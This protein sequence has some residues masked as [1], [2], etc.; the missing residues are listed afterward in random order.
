MA[1]M[2]RGAG[3][4]VPSRRAALPVMVHRDG[5]ATLAAWTQEHGEWIGAALLEHGAVLFRG[6]GVDSEQAFR[7]ASAALCG[8]LLDYVYRSTPRTTVGDRVYTA[9]EYPAEV[10]IPMHNE[11]AFQ[12]TWPMKLAFCCVRP[13]A[14]GGETPLARTAAVTRRIDPAILRAFAARGVMYVR[15]YGHGVDLPW[16]TT[17]QT[18]SPAEVEAYC[19]REGIA[20]EWLPEGRLRTRQVCQGVARHPTTGE[21]LW[22]NQAHLFHVSSL[23]PEQRD[24]LLELFDEADLPR[25]ACFGDGQPIDEATLEHVR[26]AYE[27]ETSMFPWQAGDVLLVDNMLVAHGR[28]AFTG[29]RRV[30]VAMGDPI[31]A[32][33]RPR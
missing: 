25:H 15:N 19:A 32:A 2:S 5:A 6:F 13:A 29:A 33:V 10:S 8:P 9:T 7:H 3:A 1:V 21:E 31:P 26:R 16:E 22:F 11:N 23:G 18:S 27:A 28:T 24:T 30:L 17:F 4:E 20:C 14:T 12:R